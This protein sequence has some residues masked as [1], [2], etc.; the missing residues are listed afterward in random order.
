MPSRSAAR[1]SSGTSPTGSAAAS[2]SSRRVSAGS[3]VSWR[4]KPCSMRLRQRHLH[5]SPKPPA[6]RDRR[7]PARQLEQRER[8]AAGLAEDPVPHARV[9]RPGDRRVQ[10]PAG[11]GRRPGPRS[12]A[13]AVP[14]ALL[15]PDSRSAKTSPTRS[16]S[17]RRATNASVCTDTRSSHCASSMMQRSGCSSA[18]SASRLEHRQADQEAIRRRARRSCR[19]P[20]SARRAAGPAAARDGRASV[21]TAHAGRRS[22]LHLGLDARGPGDPASLRGGRGDPAGRSCRCPPR[23]AGPAPGSGPRVSATSRSSTSRSRTRSSS[24]ARE[25]WA[26]CMYNRIIAARAHQP[27]IERPAVTPSRCRSAHD[28]RSDAQCSKMPTTSP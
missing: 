1:H 13:P 28:S 9:E 18:A 2:S 24:P 10:Q 4:T 7:P 19:T 17:R 22:E 5:G 8:V 26:S 3:G 11:V 6:T 16:A 14:R 12:P 25:K 27:Q 15:A 20:C 23:R 21:R